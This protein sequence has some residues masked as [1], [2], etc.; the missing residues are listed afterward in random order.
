MHF[1]RP[2]MDHTK[3]VYLINGKITDVLLDLRRSSVTYKRYCLAIDLT[4]HLNAL[5]IP[6]GI[7]HGFLSRDEDTIV[8]YNQTTCYSKDHD[9]GILWN[10]FGYD[11]GLFDPI[12]SS[13]DKNLIRLEDFNSPFS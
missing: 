3:L 12:L 7:A 8:V 2:P 11:W 10:S 5:L 6:S 13:R 1:Q 9:D 4:A